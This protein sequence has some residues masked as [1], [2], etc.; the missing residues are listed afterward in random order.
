MQNTITRWTEPKSTPILERASPNLLW[1]H[2]HNVVV[3]TPFVKPTDWHLFANQTE[4]LLNW[5]PHIRFVPATMGLAKLLTELGWFESVGQAKKSGFPHTRQIS[6]G[7]TELR[8]GWKIVWIW[9][10]QE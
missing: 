6:P 2:T 3:Q 4:M 8:S 10:P 5:V 1:P 9:N 7:W